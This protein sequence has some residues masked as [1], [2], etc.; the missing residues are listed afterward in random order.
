MYDSGREGILV[1]TGHATAN[2][3]VTI[4]GADV[5]RAL[6]NDFVQNVLFD[7]KIPLYRVGNEPARLQPSPELRWQTSAWVVRPESE[8]PENYIGNNFSPQHGGRIIKSNAATVTLDEISNYTHRT[9][10]LKGLRVVSA[11]N[12]PAGEVGK[13]YLSGD[14]IVFTDGMV[15]EYYF[16]LDCEIQYGLP[17][18]NWRNYRDVSIKKVWSPSAMPFDT[19][20]P[21]SMIRNYRQE[22][23]SLFYHRVTDV[24]TLA[25]SN[26]VG[27]HHQINTASPGSTV[28]WA[29]APGAFSW[30]I[31]SVE[32][33]S[34]VRRVLESGF[35]GC[36]GMQ[37]FTA[38]GLEEIRFQSFRRVGVENFFLGSR[39]RRIENN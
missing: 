33:P 11:P 28:Q 20:T 15:L 23:L 27:G 35:Y 3:D 12:S 18:G 21:G 32:L 25:F 22:H 30:G 26:G 10:L 5:S 19:T 38:M 36:L 8:F 17:Y 39:M 6:D 9:P 24:G 37:E 16:D 31:E 7:G 4:D 13:I 34:T 29:D 2:F 1:G 14:D